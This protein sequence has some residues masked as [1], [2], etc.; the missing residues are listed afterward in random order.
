MVEQGEAGE[1]PVDGGGGGLGEDRG[2]RNPFD[3]EVRR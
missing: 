1:L 2:E 3:F